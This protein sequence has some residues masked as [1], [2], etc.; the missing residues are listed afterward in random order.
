MDGTDKACTPG[1]PLFSQAALETA[2]D[3][4]HLPVFR[5]LAAIVAGMQRCM[6]SGRL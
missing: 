6:N 3:P 1:F 4:T 2:A 5:H